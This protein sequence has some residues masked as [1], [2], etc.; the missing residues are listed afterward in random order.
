[1]SVLIFTD[2]EIEGLCESSFI[3]GAPGDETTYHRW[4]PLVFTRYEGMKNGLLAKLFDRV[5]FGTDTAD[6]HL[7]ECTPI[8]SASDGICFNTYAGVQRCYFLIPFVCR[9]LREGQYVAVH[10][11][12]GGWHPHYHPTINVTVSPEGI[13]EL[14]HGFL[15]MDAMFIF[16]S[17]DGTYE[18][19]AHLFDE[20]CEDIPEKKG[21]H[22]WMRPKEE[23]DVE[24]LLKRLGFR[25]DT[26][27]AGIHPGTAP[28]PTMQE[29]DSAEWNVVKTDDAI[30]LGRVECYRLYLENPV[31]D[32][33][34]FCK[35]EP[36]IYVMMTSP[37][38]SRP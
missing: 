32:P 4:G 6:L 28:N 16:R 14:W 35:M 37:M 27:T 8:D 31:S 24:A 9:Y 29:I 33:T 26:I 21:W 38:H 3:E 11:G 13:K 18:P 10:V 17:R 19:L 36:E 15:D 25:P 1:M 20:L 22:T 5:D 2:R 7:Y 34:A 30:K 23:I 12:D